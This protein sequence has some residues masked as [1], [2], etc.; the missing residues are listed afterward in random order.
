MAPKIW[1]LQVRLSSRRES[2]QT[3]SIVWEAFRSDDMLQAFRSDMLQAFRPDML[4]A[5]NHR[6]VALHR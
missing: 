3:Q 1:R 5:S 4:Q 2:Q 6:L